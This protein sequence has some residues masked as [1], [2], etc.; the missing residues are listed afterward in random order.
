MTPTRR[1][2]PVFARF[3]ARVSPS[4]ER[5]GAATHRDALL[6]GLTGRVIDIGAGNGL[7]FAHY[8]LEVAGVLAVEPETHL[9]AL[10]L[11]NAQKATVPIEVVDGVA[12]Q[13]PADDETFDAAVVALVLCSVSNV[14]RAL[15]E[16]HRVIKPGGQLRFFE[17]VRADSPGLR[18]TQRLLDATVWPTLCGGCHAGRDIAGAIEGAGFSIQKLDRFPFPD[19]PV[20]VPTSPHILGVAIRG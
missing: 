9:R 14:T 6:A 3:Y 10:A 18:R 4:M 15:H 11:R 20:P 16:M 7:N 5:A 19:G 17:H 8:P 1:R 2:H 12:E 13:L